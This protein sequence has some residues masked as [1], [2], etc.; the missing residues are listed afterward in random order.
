MVTTEQPSSFKIKTD[1]RSLTWYLI[2]R[3]AVI[4]FLLG[5]S[6]VF[7]LQGNLHH[8]SATPLF[9]LIGIAYCEAL[10]SAVFL[11]K[12]KNIYRFAQVQIIW[13]LIFV[14]VLI[15]LSGG[16]ESIFSFAYLLIIVSAS[17]LL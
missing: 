5:G 3:T 10:L 17:F 4:T 15:L 9:I 12:T 2:C 6:G 13:D 8:I 7:Y 14:T 16:V 11:G 1:S